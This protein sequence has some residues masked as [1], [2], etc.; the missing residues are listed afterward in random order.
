VRVFFPSACL[1]L[2][3]LATFPAEARIFNLNKE[4]FA[5]YLSMNY[6]ASQVGDDLF[7][8]GSAATSYSSKL[9][10]NIGGEFGF[11]S[12]MGPVSLRFGFEVLKPAALQGVKARDSGGSTL[13]E[14]ES[15]LLGLLPKIGAD[16]NF[17]TRPSY[18]IFAY[19]AVGQ[20]HL[21]V[22]NKYTNLA[23]A[24][25][26]DFESEMKS[27]APSLS[28]GLGFEYAAFDLTSVV[29][30]LGYRQLKFRKLTYAAGVTDTSGT[31]AVG[32]VV[33]TDTGENRALDF[34]GWTVNLG[35][36][37]WLF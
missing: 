15:D 14:I 30:E 25:S 2:L 1:I 13:Y 34:S 3:F 28:G 37:W 26:S 18:R 35:A 20:A 4:K 31:H 12:M 11:I 9:G 19:G 29:L 5:S 27:N 23:V 21:T 16:V 22:K 10:N 36:R 6:G 32:D 33:V 24:P 17:V 7:L 8:G